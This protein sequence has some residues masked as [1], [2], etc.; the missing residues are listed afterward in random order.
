MSSKNRTTATS[1]DGRTSAI[2][3]EDETT[4]SERILTLA[5]DPEHTV[6][7]APTYEAPFGDGATVKS[8]LGTAWGDSED[9]E[10]GDDDPKA[11]IDEVWA[12][13]TS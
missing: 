4:D 1:N 8:I 9:G 2:A 12:D 3:D 13:L 11:V 5:S 6:Q 10:N 7:K